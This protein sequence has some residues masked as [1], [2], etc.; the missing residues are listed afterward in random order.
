[1]ESSA[2]NEATVEES[3]VGTRQGKW[4][5]GKGTAEFWLLPLHLDLEEFFENLVFNCL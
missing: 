2:G 1:M 5:G 3:D 4:H